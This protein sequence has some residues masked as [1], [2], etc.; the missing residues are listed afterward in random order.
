MTT[1][2]NS[3][4]G[5]GMVLDRLRRRLMATGP[6]HR[7]NNCNPGAVAM[8]H[9]AIIFA[10]FV[11][12]QPAKRLDMAKTLVAQMAAGQFDN[13]DEVYSCHLGLE[14]SNRVN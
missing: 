4:I 6:P 1:T 9:A 12:D 2:P 11:A 10:V 7:Y 8:F 5:T 3:L 14:Y 13:R